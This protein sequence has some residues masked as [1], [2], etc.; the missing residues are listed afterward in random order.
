MPYTQDNRIC[1]FTSVLGN[2]A[3]LLQRLS[4]HE[5]VSLPFSFDVTL[6][7]PDENLDLAALVGTGITITLDLPT[8][9]VR[10]VSAI[11]AHIAQGKADARFVTYHARI[12]PW[13]WLLTQCSDCRIFQNK[14]VPEIAKNVFDDHN[15]ADYEFR[16]SEEHLPRPFCVQYGETD[17]AFIS[18]LLE[19][20][21]ISYE[22]TPSGI[23]SISIVVREPQLDEDL[24]A[25]VTGRIKA[26]LGA[27]SG[28]VVRGLALVMIVGEGVRHTVGV[29]ARATAA[30]A[31][32]GVNIE[33]IN[34][35]SSEISVM[36]GVK[37]SDAP[38]AVR[39]LYREFF[40]QR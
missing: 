39:S 15:L 1:T 21:G 22:H 32:A 24:Q 31:K 8:G 7:S 2:D 14:T 9:D 29:A 38:Q 37:D 12:V 34:Q 30:F 28:V 13:L 35:G 16:L 3:L 10:Y 40:E 19:E 5:G 17:F 20:E 18:R 27:D 23:D 25:R 33:M 36:F 6:L 26:E 11:I 4:G